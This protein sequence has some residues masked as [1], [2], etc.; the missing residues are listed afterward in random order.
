[1]TSQLAPVVEIPQKKARSK[2][3]SRRGMGTVWQ[4]K[5]KLANGTP[6]TSEYFWISYHDQ[7]GIRHSENTGKIT[8]SEAVE[9]LA[10]RLNQVRTGEIDDHVKYRDVTLKQINDGLRAQYKIKGR[11]TTAK[12]ERSLGRLESHFGAACPVISI[13]AEKIEGYRN[14]RL[15]DGS[16]PSSPTVS[17]ELAALK[18]ALRLGYKTDK[19]KKVPHIEIPDE[20]DRAQEGEFSPAQMTTLLGQLPPHMVSLVR[21]LY[22][23]GMRIE[24]PLGLKWTEVRLDLRTLRLPGRRTKNKEAKPLTLDGPVLDIIKAQRKLLDQKFPT[25]EWVFPNARGER[26]T[27][28]QA[29]GPFKLAC[30]RGKITEGFTAWD[31]KP[32]TPGF[33]D[34]RR[35]F[36]REA[37]RC[38]VPHSEIMRIG[39]W[40]TY[41]MLLRYLGANEDRM[42]RAFKLMNKGF[43]GI[44]YSR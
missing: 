29:H 43:K 6:R 21:F 19:V 12:L 23:T 11:R 8:K 4:P 3:R 34:L 37:D 30:M 25:C 40:K 27:Y 5:Y 10:K 22:R 15:M 16:R 35:T 32:R 18:A 31:G 7:A 44:A 36:A 2:R 28:D 24:E 1:M 39:G 38:G 26:L 17:R 33:H 20:R 14:A 9:E 41:A 42:R 13:T